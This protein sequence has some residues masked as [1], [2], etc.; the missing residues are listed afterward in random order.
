[1]SSSRLV[2]EVIFG[3][4]FEFVKSSGLL[5]VSKN[6]EKRL[7]QSVGAALD[8]A[9]AA[10]AACAVPPLPTFHAGAP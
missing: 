10:G 9:Q 2:W 7:C 8:K 5:F 3:E 1:V 6:E 4:M